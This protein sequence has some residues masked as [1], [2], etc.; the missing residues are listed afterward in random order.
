MRARA[1]TRSSETVEIFWSMPMTAERIGRG[2]FDAELIFKGERRTLT[3]EA[4]S[5]F[6][7][8]TRGTHATLST[9]QDRT[10]SYK[11]IVLSWVEILKVK[12]KYTR[13]RNV[14]SS[15]NMNMNRAPRLRLGA[16][17]QSRHWHQ[18]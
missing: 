6:L 9:L 15:G 2:C 5:L 12:Y 14:H 8:A 18:P 1:S 4:A 3:D 7:C 17:E 10:R 13:V 16:H 11:Y